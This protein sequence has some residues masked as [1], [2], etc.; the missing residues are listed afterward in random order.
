MRLCFALN[1]RNESWANSNMLNIEEL[2]LED[3]QYRRVTNRVDDEYR[4]S[5]MYGKSQ[6]MADRTFSTTRP[7]F[8][9]KY[10]AD[11]ITP[12]WWANTGRPKIP[13]SSIANAAMCNSETVAET[14]SIACSDG[15][16]IPSELLC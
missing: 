2:W 7:M 9:E 1:E 8:F 14:K 16:T 13:M 12:I 5:E 3:K 15:K 11:R 4:P 6:R 10:W